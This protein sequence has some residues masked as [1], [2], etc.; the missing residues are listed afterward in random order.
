M[1]KSSGSF[2]AP[3][4]E[5]LYENLLSIKLDTLVVYFQACHDYLDLATSQG[6]RWQKMLQYEHEQR[7]RLEEMVEQ[8]AKQ[9]S[10]FEKQARKTL[11]HAVNHNANK[12]EGNSTPGEYRWN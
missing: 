7:L 10:N 6:K 11:A 9:H 1:Y 12:T 5:A 2:S 8:L 4:M 3:L